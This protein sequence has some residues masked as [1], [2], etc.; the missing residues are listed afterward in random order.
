MN[1]TA[2]GRAG[3]PA[4]APPQSL[5]P[6]QAKLIERIEAEIARGRRRILAVLPTGGGKTVV[7]AHM[8]AAQV[9]TGGKVLFLAHRRELVSQTSRKLHGVKVDAGVIQADHPTRPLAPVQV[10][11]IQT[12]HAR[13]ILG[14]PVPEPLL[15]GPAAASCAVLATGTGVPVFSG[16]DAA[17]A[18]PT[19]QVRLFGKPTV[20]GRRRVAVTLARGDAPEQ[21]RER[22]REAAAALRITLE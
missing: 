2:R 11:S 19:S 12:L 5:R 7:A 21:A 22:A 16:V 6:Y 8:I 9:G 15:L 4:P 13:A 20:D 10:A 3:G 1:E 17:L 18:V 14:L